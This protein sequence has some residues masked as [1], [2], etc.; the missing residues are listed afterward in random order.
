M[1]NTLIFIIV[2]SFLGLTLNYS[3]IIAQNE[4]I[5]I[6][7]I[8]TSP[9]S[10]AILDVNAI[11]PNPKGLLVPRLNTVRRDAIVSPAVSLLIYN[12]DIGCIQYWSGSAWVNLGCG[13]YSCN[14]VGGSANGNPATDTC[15]YTITLTLTGYNGSIQ[16][17]SSTDNITFTN[18][19]GTTTPYNT[20]VNDSIIYFRAQVTDSSCSPAYSDTIT[21]TCYETLCGPDQWTQKANFGGNA[22]YGSVGFSIGTKGYIGTGIS[23][24]PVYYKDFWGYDP[25]TD[26]WTQKADFGGVGDERELAVGFSISSKGYIGLGKND[27]TYFKD[28][29]EYDTSINSWTQKADFDST[30]RYGAVGFSINAKGYVG[31]GY[32]NPGGSPTY[33]KD[34]W[35]YDPGSD[36]WT[37]KADFGGDARSLAVG[38]SIGTKGYIGTGYSPA[39][40]KDFWEYDPGLDIWTQKADFGGTA[41]RIAVG[42]SIGTKGY[43]G[44]GTDGP[45]Y[46]DF[47]EYAQASNTW[48]QKADFGGTA[49]SLATGFSIGTR[50]YIGTGN[51]GS[52]KN[53]FWEYC[54]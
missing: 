29:W 35:E 4:G 25:V 44:T 30:A 40:H 22:R 7:E 41:R 39:Y 48:A 6:N 2:I 8:G 46:K 38:F 50:G 28:F 24:G 33:H 21:A 3:N 18:I 9:D 36:I 10:S 15:G 1:K 32:Y 20:T 26:I 53:D 54:P 5:S 37:R 52:A 13:G 45:Y 34:F 42:F 43:I 31:T 47:W 16:W 14:S 11:G 17:Q 51:D 23:A 27:V 12:I 49:R 19:G